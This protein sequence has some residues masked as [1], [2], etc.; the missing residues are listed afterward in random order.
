[1][2]LFKGVPGLNRYD[3]YDAYIPVI[4]DN[5]QE[6]I[7]GNIR[8]LEA[9]IEQLE[10]QLKD[11]Q[12]IADVVFSEEF[13]IDIRKYDDLKKR[14]FYD[15]RLSNIN[16]HK[17]RFNSKSNNPHV[18]YILQSTLGKSLSLEEFLA[19][20]IVGGTTPSYSAI[21]NYKVLKTINVNKDG[22]IDEYDDDQYVEKASV[23]LENGDI[24][25]TTHGEGRGKFAI[26]RGHE[27]A[28]TDANCSIIRIKA[29]TIKLEYLTFYLNSFIGR[30]LF[31]YLESETK[32]VRY[33]RN[34]DLETLPILFDDQKQ[35]RIVDSISTQL[36]RRKDIENEIRVKRDKINNIIQAAIR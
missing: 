17:L 18:D 30:G 2:S 9:Q 23:L 5:E 16:D 21:K 24:L 13:K 32:S 14:K 22:T 1:L 11:T 6:K 3:A 33:M 7:L 26:Y 28:T 19:T 25:V 8:P 4:D 12:G 20:A 36:T 15:I 34:D 35:L 29:N 10:S 27:P 31:R